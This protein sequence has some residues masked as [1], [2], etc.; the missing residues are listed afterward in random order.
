MRKLLILIVCSFALAAC[1]SAQP[2]APPTPADATV[3][4]VATSEPASPTAAQPTPTAAQPSGTAA[5]Y[6]GPTGA[7]PG[8][9]RPPVDAPAELSEAARAR[10][11]THLGA[12]GQG[13]VLQAAESKQWPDASLGCPAADQVYEQVIIPGYLLTFGDGSRNYA[14]HTS[15]TANPGEPMV[16][17][18]NQKPIDLSAAG[19]PPAADPAGQAMAEL[20][21]QDL[22]KTLSIAPSDVT[23]VSIAPVQWNDSS[24]GCAK[25]GQSYLQVITPGFM[26]RLNAQGQGYEYHTD[27]TS[28]VVQC[29]PS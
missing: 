1:G 8:P 11:A 5:P 27:S 4:A 2:A 7:Y 19:T 25:P 18:E 6:P 13:L 12:A 17:C 23:V 9:G 24:L 15:L 21:K 20:A 26:I 3:P 14:V 22:A 16:L 29:V 10:L 28:Q